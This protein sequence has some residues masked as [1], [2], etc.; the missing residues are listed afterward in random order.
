MQETRV[1][2]LVWEDP[3]EKEMATLVFLP[4]KSHGGQRSLAYCSPWGCKELDMTERLNNSNNKHTESE[5][6]WPQ[7]L[8][9]EE[10]RLNAGRKS[11]EV[12]WQLDKGGKCDCEVQHRHRRL[13]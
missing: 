9:V 10:V 8:K 12:C 1:R 13:A 2:S 11:V 7:F 4:G 6:L 5:D 3:L